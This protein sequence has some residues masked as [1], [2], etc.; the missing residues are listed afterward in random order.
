MSYMLCGIML[1]IHTTHLLKN[2]SQLHHILLSNKLQ[3][4][5]WTLFLFLNKRLKQLI[6]NN[7]EMSPMRLPQQHMKDLKKEKQFQ[8]LMFQNFL[9]LQKRELLLQDID[10]H[11]SL[12]WF[13]VQKDKSNS[14]KT[15]TFFNR[16]NFF[17][18]KIK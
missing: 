13:L 5:L 10:L 18:L 11:T 12:N 6:S 7:L 1:F 14:F 9:K 16:Q 17:F 15:E 8:I 3:Q 4:I 2:H